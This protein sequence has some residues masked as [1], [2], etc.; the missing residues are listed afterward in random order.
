SAPAYMPQL[1]VRIRQSKKSHD[2]LTSQLERLGDVPSL[3]ERNN[4]ELFSLSGALMSQETRLKSLKMQSKEAFEVYKGLGGSFAKRLLNRTK[5]RDRLVQIARS[6]WEEVLA[7]QRAEEEKVL[8]SAKLVEQAKV[9]EAELEFKKKEYDCLAMELE[10]LND[11]LFAGPTPEFPREDFYEWE[12]DVLVETLQLVQ[13]EMNREKRARQLLKQAEPV[14]HSCLDELRRALQHSVEIGVPQNKKYSRQILVGGSAGAITKAVTPLILNSKTH[15]GKFHTLVAKARGS[16][17]LIG[18]VPELKIIELYLLPGQKHSKAV[19][20]RQL[21]ASL[22]TSYSQ[23]RSC[24]GYLKQEI[25]LSG[26][27]SRYLLLEKGKMESELQRR[28]KVRDGVRRRIIVA[29]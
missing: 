8:N 3:I 18:R 17:T 1:R 19:S 7:Q 26:E 24:I 10:S 5:G 25:R 20:E 15:S 23:C 14:I 13:A 9:K 16:Q 4:S 22:E 27:R 12:V 29:V 21:H 11:S 2:L 6:R 28:K